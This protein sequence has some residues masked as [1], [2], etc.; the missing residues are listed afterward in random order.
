MKIIQSGIFRKKVKKL[1]P[2]QKIQLDEAVRKI[3]DNPAIGEQKKGDLL[4][5]FVHNE[6]MTFWNR[7]L[8]ASW[9][10]ERF[11]LPHVQHRNDKAPVCEW[12]G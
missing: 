7:F 9:R 8:S 4:H 5:V 11:L 3:A 10:I 1:S 6:E 2:S 12:G